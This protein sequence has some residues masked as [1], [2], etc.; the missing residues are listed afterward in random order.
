VGALPPR[1]VRARRGGVQGA[2]AL[3]PARPDIAAHLGMTYAKLGQK[4]AALSELKRALAAGNDLPNRAE[5]E[6]LVKTLSVAP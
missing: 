1:R 2:K 4:T 3:A 6:G 5:L